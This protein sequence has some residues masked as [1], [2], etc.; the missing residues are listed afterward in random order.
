MIVITLL[1]PST[2]ID[3][4][5]AYTSRELITKVDVSDKN[6]DTINNKQKS[7]QVVI[8][9]RINN[10]NIDDTSVDDTSV[11]DY[12]VLDKNFESDLFAYARSEDM[13]LSR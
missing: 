6:N 8:N 7:D 13:D 1:V 10:T 2:G 4:T 3:Q 12:Y 11:D 5:I 9:T